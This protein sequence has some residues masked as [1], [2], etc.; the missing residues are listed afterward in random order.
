MHEREALFSLIN[1]A[2]QRAGG[3]ESGV[4]LTAEAGRVVRSKLKSGDPHKFFR[5][6][7]SGLTSSLRNPVGRPAHA[8]SDQFSAVALHQKLN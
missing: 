6:F 5:F 4:K 8:C 3:R 1:E 7:M 2:A